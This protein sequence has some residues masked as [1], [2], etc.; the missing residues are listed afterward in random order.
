MA[1]DHLEHGEVAGRLKENAVSSGFKP[2]HIIIPALQFV[3]YTL[4]TVQAAYLLGID[5]APQNWWITGL[6]IGAA[7]A[8]IS[9]WLERETAKERKGLW[10]AIYTLRLHSSRPPRRLKT[11]RDIPDDGDLVLGLLMESG[12]Q[13]P[14]ATDISSEALEHARHPIRGFD[15]STIDGLRDLDDAVV[16]ALRRYADEAQ[17]GQLRAIRSSIISDAIR[18]FP[19]AH[20]SDRMKIAAWLRTRVS[21][22]K[23]DS[24]TRR[25]VM[26]VA[27]TMDGEE[28]REVVGSF[29]DLTAWMS[30]TPPENIGDLLGN[31]GPVVLSL[32]EELARNEYGSWVEA[33]R[34]VVEDEQQIDSHTKLATLHRGDRYSI[35]LWHDIKEMNAARDVAERLMTA[36][37]VT[38]SVGRTVELTPALDQLSG[39]VKPHSPLSA[40]QRGD[41]HGAHYEFKGL[42]D[43]RFELTGSGALAAFFCLQELPT[44]GVF[45]HGAYGR[46]YQFLFGESLQ[47]ALRDH[48]QL[49]PTDPVAKDAL[50]WAAGP[51]VERAGDDNGYM[52]SWISYSPTEGLVARKVTLDQTGRAAVCR[53]DTIIPPRGKMFY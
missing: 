27:A 28:T 35:N 20:S 40:T 6:I 48:F 8:S 52:V 39:L 34:A 11:V 31:S 22:A 50:A 32:A 7:I 5:A 49:A 45:W 38:Q 26:M 51:Q 19:K 44:L 10:E 15:G 33:R 24:L 42:D 23:N 14:W 25:L 17:P 30:K 43:L 21:R 53:G 37:A 9:Y 16:F 36:G 47:F 1:E 12:G 2:T 13:W 46:D 3:A 41:S 29:D 18:Q 4:A